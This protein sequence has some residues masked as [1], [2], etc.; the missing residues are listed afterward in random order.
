MRNVALLRGINVG[1]K[2]KLPMKDLVAI[3]SACGCKN[4]STFI[5]S[6][7]VIF[8]GSA[9]GLCLKIGKAIERKFG[10]RAPITFRS[11]EQLEKVVRGNPFLQENEDYLHVVF[12][13]DVPAAAAVKSLDPARSPGDRFHVSGQEIYLH[14]PNGMGQTRITNAWLDAKLSTVSTARNWR[15]TLKLLE[16]AQ[17]RA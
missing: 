8:E 11:A 6:G 14:V 5:Q 10:F 2:N 1:G 13:A 3:F 12:L 16:L 9:N 17:S 4:V 7:N 15:T